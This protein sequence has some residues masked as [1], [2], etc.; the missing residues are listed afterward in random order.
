MGKRLE[1]D[2]GTKEREQNKGEAEGM[3][4]CEGERGSEEDGDARINIYMILYQIRFFV[5]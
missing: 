5:H 2:E 1:G 4:K 3:L